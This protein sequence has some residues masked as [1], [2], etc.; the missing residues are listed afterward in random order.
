ME[1]VTAK[2]SAVSIQYIDKTFQGLCHPLR[3][4]D[5]GLWSF[6]HLSQ[7]VLQEAMAIYTRKEAFERDSRCETA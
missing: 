2:R 4:T 3:L 6:C 5:W 1:L 7:V